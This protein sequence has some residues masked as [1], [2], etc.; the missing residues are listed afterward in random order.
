M[1]ETYGVLFIYQIVMKGLS[2]LV[3]FRRFCRYWA[4]WIQQM[5]RTWRK[6]QGNSGH[7]GRA[8]EIWVMGAPTERSS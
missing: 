7:E 1:I 5:L 3:D 8:R 4:M 2:Q 6:I